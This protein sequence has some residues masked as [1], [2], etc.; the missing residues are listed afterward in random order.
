MRQSFKIA[1][2]AFGPFECALRK[3][4]HEFDLSAST[5]LKLELE[6]LELNALHR[7]LFEERRPLDEEYDVVFINTDWI[8]ALHRDRSV[9][10]LGPYLR[11]HPPEDYP[12]GWTASL[13]G[14]Q[15]IGDTVL[16]LPYHDG[17][18]CLI[19]RKDL[20]DDQDE[21]AA[22]ASQFG[23]PL[24]VPA[25]WQ[26]FRQVAG[27]F[28]RPK[29]GLWGSAVAG[30]PDCHNTVYD[31]MLQLWTRNGTL[32]DPAGKLRFHTP[33]ALEA[34]AF[35]RSLI[36][37]PGILHPGSREFDSVQLGGA[38]A[39]GHL[40]M[41]V[42][43]FG[44]AAWAETS[45]DSSVKGKI[46]LASLP[47]A[48]GCPDASLNIYWLLA[49]AKGC[50][51]PELAYAFVRHCMSPRM[52][53]LLTLEG[54]VGCRR[55]TWEDSEVLAAVP[56]FAQ[57]EALHSRSRELPRTA[58]WPAIASLIDAF[59]R[60]AANSDHPVERLLQEADTEAAGLFAPPL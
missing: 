12:E 9:L 57:L 17:P 23:S 42:N 35:Y 44:F 11:A 41:M 32:F 6:S 50:P 5:G 43:W 55:S 34:L 56:H 38:F 7:A 60:S 8:A 39:K 26:E 36:Q 10:D 3:Q 18:E 46:G 51:Q 30:F 19:Y 1:V 31:F 22:Y 52:D 14:L 29:E 47:H 40:A 54:A 15:S 59:V 48:S 20:L 4:W 2:R 28:H 37:D 27:Y 21:Q 25:T 24:R 58:D 45:A 16:G 13:L 49:I 33:A 53:K